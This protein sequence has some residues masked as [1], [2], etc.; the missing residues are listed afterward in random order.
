M[1][2]FARGTG[3][4][5]E[6]VEPFFTHC[7]F[8]LENLHIGNRPEDA[9]RLSASQFWE[10]VRWIHSTFERASSSRS[11]PASSYGLKHWFGNEGTSEQSWWPNPNGFYITNG[12]FKGAMLAAGFRPV[13]EEE[14]NWE[15]KIK[16]R[17]EVKEAL[18]QFDRNGFRRM[19]IRSGTLSVT[20]SLNHLSA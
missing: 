14:T 2:R 17:P 12:Q 19:P 11:C 3:I 5:L 15:F 6:D 18:K 13:N 20:S 10:I 1:E 8:G 4:R 16:L 9:E 7:V